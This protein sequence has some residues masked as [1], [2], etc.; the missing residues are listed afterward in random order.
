MDFRYCIV[1]CGTSG[2]R[3][4][5]ANHTTTAAPS[6][7]VNMNR[8]NGEGPCAAAGEKCLEVRTVNGAAKDGL[9]F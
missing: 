9:A 2:W 1:V 4:A 6:N 3:H 5:R 8:I 7:V